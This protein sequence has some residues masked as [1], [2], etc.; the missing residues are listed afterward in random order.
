MAIADPDL[1]ARVLADLDRLERELKALAES[2]QLSEPSQ[3]LLVDEALPL[4]RDLREILTR[5]ATDEV[6]RQGF[7]KRSLVQAGRVTQTLSDVGRLSSG[8]FG[9]AKVPEAI[10]AGIGLLD[11][12]T[13]VIG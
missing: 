10:S 3:E 8:L 2:N 6:H 1:A 7:V 11:K 9:L 5:V 4:L 13:D 12:V